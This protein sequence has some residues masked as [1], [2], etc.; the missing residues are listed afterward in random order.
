TSWQCT[1]QG[2]TPSSRH[3]REVP[4]CRP[5]QQLSAWIRFPDCWDGRRLDS[6]DHASHMAYA[7][8]G[9]C[10]ASHPVAI[11]RI[12]YR[13]TWP[14]RPRSG[15]V[16]QLGHGRLAPHAMHAAFWNAWHMP[17]L[18]QLRWDCI[19]VARACGEVSTPTRR[20]R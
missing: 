12:V 2:R 4:R 14:T 18:R 9:A 20:Q 1:G 13:V 3:V 10:P 8:R 19:E 5:G 16:V 6:A 7:V 17:T 15:S 11:M